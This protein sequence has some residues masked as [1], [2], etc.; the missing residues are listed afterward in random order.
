MIKNVDCDGLGEWRTMAQLLVEGQEEF[1]L[2][3]FDHHFPVYPM[4]NL[5]GSALDWC[6]ALA[7]ANKMQ[8]TFNPKLRR[9]FF[10]KSGK[11]D[12]CKESI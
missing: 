12:R 7:D 5:T 11:L 1:D 4:A 10:R 2:A 9:G 3:G 8:F 6:K